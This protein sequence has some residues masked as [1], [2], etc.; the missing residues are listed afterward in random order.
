MKQQPP[1]PAVAPTLQYPI[2]GVVGVVVEKVNGKLECPDPDCVLM[3]NQKDM[4][5]HLVK[6]I[7][8]DEN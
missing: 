4:V 2:G 6:K 3:F 7:Q 5:V 8:Q 1:Q